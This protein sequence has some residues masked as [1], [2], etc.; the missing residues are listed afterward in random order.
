MID[1]TV[2]GE[3]KTI[4]DTKSVAAVLLDMDFDCGRVAVAINSIF[5][6]RMDYDRQTFSAGDKVDVVAPMAGG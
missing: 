5:V 6:A 2:N 1:I 4:D 3:R